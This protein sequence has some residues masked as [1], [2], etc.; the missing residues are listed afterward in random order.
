MGSIIAAAII[1]MIHEHFCR[2]LLAI[3]GAEAGAM[4]LRCLAKGAQHCGKSEGVGYRFWMVMHG[5][6]ILCTPRH[7]DCATVVQY[8]YRIALC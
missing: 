6:L 2:R 7:A 5:R 4:A 3:I 8:R 1:I